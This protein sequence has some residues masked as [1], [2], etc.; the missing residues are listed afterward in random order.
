[1]TL[2]DPQDLQAALA[3]NRRLLAELSK[4]RGEAGIVTVDGLRMTS[5]AVA[6]LIRQL[7]EARQEVRAVADRCSSCWARFLETKTP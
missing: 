6:D 1:M 2:N 4:A 7:G 3:E 5:A